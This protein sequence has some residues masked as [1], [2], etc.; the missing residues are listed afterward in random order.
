MESPL[1][2]SKGFRRPQMAIQGRSIRGAG[3]IVHEKE[4]EKHE[5]VTDTVYKDW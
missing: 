1:F 2:L 4:L 5:E 3:R